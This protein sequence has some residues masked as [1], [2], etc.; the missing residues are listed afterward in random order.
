[1]ISFNDTKHS[2]KKK[3]TKNEQKENIEK[4]TAQQ[5][6]VATTCDSLLYVVIFVNLFFSI[7][8]KEYER[9]TPSGLKSVIVTNFSSTW[10]CTVSGFWQEEKT[11]SGILKK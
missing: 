5:L 4:A 1:M 9:D 8:T 6:R 2:Y 3:Q 7:D 11:V 10:L